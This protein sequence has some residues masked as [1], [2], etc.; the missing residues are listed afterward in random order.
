MRLKERRIGKTFQGRRV[1]PR[2]PAEADQGR[3]G[4]A[5]RPQ[6]QTQLHGQ[7][8]QPGRPVENRGGANIP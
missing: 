3:R 2:R 1:L 6:D 8:N 5:R 7:V 4:G